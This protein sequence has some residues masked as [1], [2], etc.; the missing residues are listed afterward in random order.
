MISSKLWQN[1]DLLSAGKA[2][3]NDIATSLFKACLSWL[4]QEQNRRKPPIHHN[5]KDGFTFATCPQR[6]QRIRQHALQWMLLVPRGEGWDAERPA[7]CLSCADLNPHSKREM[8]EEGHP[9][10]ATLLCT[11]SPGPPSYSP[12]KMPWTHGSQSHSSPEGFLLEASIFY[13]TRIFKM[14]SSKIKT[15]TEPSLIWTL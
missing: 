7:S 12:R 10:L 15:T 1:P 11:F 14:V 5:L 2:P 9:G 8:S 4:K 13:V 6:S 3:G